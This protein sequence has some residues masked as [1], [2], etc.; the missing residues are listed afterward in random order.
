MEKLSNRRFSIKVNLLT[1]HD[2]KLIY[3]KYNAQPE[4]NQVKINIAANV[5]A[6]GGLLLRINTLI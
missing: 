1:E 6:I 3:E 5:I 4:S 2:I